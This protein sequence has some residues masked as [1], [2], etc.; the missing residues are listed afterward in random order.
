[1][2][3]AA[4]GCATLTGTLAA[5]AVQSPAVLL[6]AAAAPAELSYGSP[7]AVTGTVLAGGS[8]A[9]GAQLEAQASAY[10]Y[11]TWTPAGTAT[12]GTDG[13]YRIELGT[14]KVNERVR[15]LD[16]SAGGAAATP[17]ALAVSPHIELAARSLAPGRVRLSARIAHAPGLSSPPVPARWYTAAQGSGVYRLATTGTTREL[18]GGVTYASASVDPPSRR[19]SWRV[20]LNPAWEAAM[21]PPGAHGP[22]PTGGFRLPA[23]AARARQRARAALEFGGQARGTPL[24]P[25]P[26]AAGIAAA[27]TWLQG[28][29]GRTAFAVVD[30]TGGLYGWHVREHFE[31]AS[32]VKVMFLTAYLQ[33]L[34]ARGQALG[35]GDR[36]RLY[37]MIHESNNEDASAVLGAVGGTAVGRVAREAGMLDYAPASGWWAYTQTSPA[38]QAQFFTQLR[39]LIP[40][41]FYRYARYLMSTIEPEQSWGVPRLA[42]PQWHV[43]FKTGALPSQGLFNEV[44]LLERGPVAFT[45]AVF[46]D[47]DPSQAYGEETIAGVGQRLLAGSLGSGRRARRV[48]GS[49]GSGTQAKRVSDSAGSGT[50]PQGVSPG[51]TRRASGAAEGRP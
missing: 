37:P 40:A 9:P 44:A 26:A 15:V 1:M 10:P 16:R 49:A 4:L 29:A 42:R 11:R 46:T 35:A 2:G 5:L 3:I 39:R 51:E 32:V 43:Y 17:V 33:M 21:G 38:D 19:F 20:C 45:V 23:A 13:S 12:S 24:P 36:A 6:T 7:A 30:S 41:R 27:R 50:P 47:G 22:C 48:S 14:P 34:Q 31:T 25:F 8:P 18:A 28:R